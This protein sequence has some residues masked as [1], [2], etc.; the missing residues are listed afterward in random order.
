MTSE[1]KI[2][3]AEWNKTNEAKMKSDV[4][5]RDFNE[6][7]FYASRIESSTNFRRSKCHVKDVKIN[8]L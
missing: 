4:I 5:S 1:D 3:S 6:K 2:V 8:H 7:R